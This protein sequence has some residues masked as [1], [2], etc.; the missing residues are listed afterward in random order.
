VGKSSRTVHCGPCAG[1]TFHSCPYAAVLVHS[2]I[3]YMNSA[4]GPVVPVEALMLESAA[5]ATGRSLPVSLPITGG[6][7]PLYGAVVGAIGALVFGWADRRS[8]ISR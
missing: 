5:N 7:S 4:G 2:Y 8:R 1:P 6:F 3:L